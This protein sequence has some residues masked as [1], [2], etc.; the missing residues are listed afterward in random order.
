MHTERCR[1]F[2][3]LIS[4]RQYN[5]IDYTRDETHTFQALAD[6]ALSIQSRRKSRGS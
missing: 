2:N 5:N 6:E 4:E 1:C 3:A